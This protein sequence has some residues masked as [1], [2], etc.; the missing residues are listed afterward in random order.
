MWN[1]FLVG[2]GAILGAWAR[3][4]V[5]S[6]VNPMVPFFPFATLLVNWFGC[7]LIGCAMP[8]G[9][10]AP[11]LSMEQRLFVVT[12]FLGSFTTFS[13]FSL[14]VLYFY[15]HSQPI[16]AICAW[17][18]QAIGCLVMTFLGFLVMKFLYA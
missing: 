16:T 18:L 15:G 6:W 13:T 17:F 2:A 10:N 3:W 1:A 5:A 4:G 9:L 11:V 8:V 14:E 12:G 7:F